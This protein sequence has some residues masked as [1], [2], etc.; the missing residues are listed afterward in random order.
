MQKVGEYGSVRDA[1]RALNCF[2][3]NICAVL[4]GKNKWCKGHTFSD[5]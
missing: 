2:G 3:Q 4:S 5:V 1:A